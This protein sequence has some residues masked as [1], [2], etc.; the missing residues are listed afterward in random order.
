MVD[1]FYILRNLEICY[2]DNFFLAIEFHK[3]RFIGM[4]E[5]VNRSRGLVVIV[6]KDKGKKKKKSPSPLE[7]SFESRYFNCH[8]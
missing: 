1:S 6:N 4:E 8:E 2:L 7:L 5:V 3:T